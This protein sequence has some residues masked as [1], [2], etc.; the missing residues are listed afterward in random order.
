M[1]VTPSGLSELRLDSPS[2][3]VGLHPQ[4]AAHT[5]QRN[6]GCGCARSRRTP[7]RSFRARPPAPRPAPAAAPAMSPDAA[8]P[9]PAPARKRE[10]Q[11]A[12]TLTPARR[13][14]V[15]SAHSA[16]PSPPAFSPGPGSRSNGAA[17]IHGL[18]EQHETS[19]NASIPREYGQV[20]AGQHAATT[21]KRRPGTTRGGH[22]PDAGPLK[23]ARRPSHTVTSTEQRPHTG[24]SRTDRLW[25]A[26][27]RQ[28][29]SLHS[30]ITGWDQVG[31]VLGGQVQPERA[32]LRL[33]A[34]VASALGCA[35]VTVLRAW[36]PR[37]LDAAP[38][39]GEGCRLHRR[40]GLGGKT[41]Q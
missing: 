19:R 16:R 34:P 12:A 3:R 17:I 23:P 20:R 38:K 30:V 22:A 32:D 6:P 11:P 8:S 31:V 5:R 25:R 15:R 21:S 41:G 13:R 35:T 39:S 33:Q 37:F 28:R 36:S 27:R 7:P 14:P 9:P 18:P 40:S 2:S 24:P 26:C 1:T 29:L 4:K 10:P